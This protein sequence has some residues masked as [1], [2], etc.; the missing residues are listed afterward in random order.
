MTSETDAYNIASFILPQDRIILM[1]NIMHTYAKDFDTYSYSLFC[2]TICANVHA[3][4]L[5]QEVT[6]S[7]TFCGNNA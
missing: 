2:S 3:S 4:V 6:L 7:Q 5:L 1:G